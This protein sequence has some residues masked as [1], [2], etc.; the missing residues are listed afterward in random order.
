MFSLVKSKHFLATTKTSVSFEHNS[1]TKPK[2]STVP[3]MKKRITSVS[4][5]SGSTE[6]FMR[7]LEFVLRVVECLKSASE[8]LLSLQKCME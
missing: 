5:E 3:A 4:A 6:E 7:K 1:R 8:A 2:H